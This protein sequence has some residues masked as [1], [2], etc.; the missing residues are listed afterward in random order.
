MLRRTPGD[1]V[2]SVKSA[3]LTTE[4]VANAPMTAQGDRRIAF[5]L[6]LIAALLLLVTALL[7]LVVGIGF[8]VTGS[9]HTGAG[10]IGSAVVDAVVALLIGL[11]AFLGQARGS[12]RSVL[13]GVVL[14]VLAVVG[15]IAL[16]FGGDLFAILAAL[17]ALV[18]G[19]VFLLAGR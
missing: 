2:A 17:L 11:F 13:A 4:S 18:A 7:H 8:L 3:E 19:V 6:G 12:E 9:V 10:S 14:V 5:A 16:G 1:A 15:W